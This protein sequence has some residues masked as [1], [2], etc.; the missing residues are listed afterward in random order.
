MVC[1]WRSLAYDLAVMG[2]ATLPPSQL[3]LPA[4]DDRL[5][6]PETRFE[7]HDGEVRYVSPA[8]E[9]HGSR[10]SKL[11]ALLEAYVNLEF[12]VAVD[13]LTRTST[14][15]DFAPDASVFPRERDPQTGTRQIEQL[16]FEIVSTERLAHAGEKARKLLARG[17]RRVF[18]IDVERKRALEWATR[19]DSWQM[20]ASN[21]AIEDAVFALPVPIEALVSASHTDD[22][23]AAALIAKGN[24]V[25][26]GLVTGSRNDGVAHSIL[27]FL[28]ARG[29]SVSAEGAQHILACRDPE[30]LEVWLKAAATVLSVDELLSLDVAGH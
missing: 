4:V 21:A 16:A 7:I 2:A 14:T 1:R 26:N 23:I 11:S 18:A 13:M 25:I 5:V 12:D 3:P 20:L 30:K 9:L 28:R 24:A 8:D 15:N 22:A 29:V 6:M 19:L 17:V 27:V 10:H